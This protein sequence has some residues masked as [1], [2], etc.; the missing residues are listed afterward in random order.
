MTLDPLI[1][2]FPHGK[3]RCD[4]LSSRLQTDLSRVIK[5]RERPRLIPLAYLTL[6]DK[7]DFI[8]LSPPEAT[9]KT[10]GKSWLINSTG[11][12]K[13]IARKWINAFSCLSRY[14]GNFSDN[15]QKVFFKLFHRCRCLHQN[16]ANALNKFIIQTRS[17][18]FI[19]SFYI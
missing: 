1:K 3:H 17:S 19:Y 4:A 12:L 16:K 9:L 7:I 15:T 11:S 2:A 10:Y 5:L 8:F 14:S 18:H 6:L 13:H